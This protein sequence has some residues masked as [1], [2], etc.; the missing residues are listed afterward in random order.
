MP[1]DLLLALDR[2]ALDKETVAETL[3]CILKYREDIA[4]FQRRWMQ[5][6]FRDSLLGDVMEKLC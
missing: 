5:Q 3:G 6:G 2:T 4:H 1:S